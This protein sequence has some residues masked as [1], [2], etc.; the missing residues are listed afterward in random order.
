[1]KLRTS[2]RFCALTI[3]LVMLMMAVAGCGTSSSAAPA[4]APAA[5][6]AP[7]ASEPA[8]PA[9]PAEPVV[10]K[11]EGDEFGNGAI[12]THGGVSS[13]SPYAS[14]AG[15][16]ILKA[17]GN[18]VDA[19]IA[20]VFAAGVVEPNLSGIG[21][22]GMMNI[23]LKDSKTY[24]ILEYME[25]VPAAVTPGWFNPKEDVNT[26]KN[27][28]VPG[29]VAG[30]L[31]A[32]EKFGTM[33]PEQVMAPAIKLAREGFKMDKRLA[34]AVSGS[35]DALPA[36]ALR[37]YTNDGIPYKEGDLFKNPDLAN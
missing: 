18:A 25:T 24:E 7:V 4:P 12:G 13:C 35:Y 27:A 26:A 3:A 1:M 33:K 14:Q 10:E 11:M 16:D 5:S 31:T 22:C 17:G 2:T 20:T 21:G 6:V 15:I 19:A 9:A 32:L 29:Q 28:A 37:V 8:A 23:Y 30:L 36:E 34:D